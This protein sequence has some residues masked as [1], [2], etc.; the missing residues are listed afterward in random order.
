MATKEH[1]AAAARRAAAEQDR[2]ELRAALKL[3][4]EGYVQRR[5]DSRVEA[6]DA[7]LKALGDAPANLATGQPDEDPPADDGL[8]PTGKPPIKKVATAKSQ[9]PAS[10][11]AKAPAPNSNPAD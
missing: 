9:E 11:T 8:A 10:G 2:T 1:A 3:E 6:I 5:L 7:Q 4:R